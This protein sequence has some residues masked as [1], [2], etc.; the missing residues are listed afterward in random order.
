MWLIRSLFCSEVQSNIIYLLVVQGQL[1]K[2]PVQSYATQKRLEVSPTNS[3]RIQSMWNLLAPIHG[4]IHWLRATQLFLSNPSARLRL[5]N[6]IAISKL[7]TYIT[8]YVHIHVLDRVINTKM[9]EMKKTR[10]FFIFI[11]SHIGGNTTRAAIS[12]IAAIDRQ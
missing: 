9:I 8:L 4:R 2:Q 10:R 7:L 3:T 1:R 5:W 11:R 12:V 6:S